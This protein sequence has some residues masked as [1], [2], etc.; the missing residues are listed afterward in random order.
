MSQRYLWGLKECQLPTGIFE[1]H[2]YDAWSDMNRLDAVSLACAGGP[3]LS[4]IFKLEVLIRWA[5]HAQKKPLLFGLAWAR[6]DDEYLYEYDEK[7]RIDGFKAI[8]SAA[9]GYIKTACMMDDDFDR[10]ALLMTV[11]VDSVNRAPTSYALGFE[12]GRWFLDR[13]RQQEED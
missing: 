6:I 1:Q 9:M 2:V 8:E 12:I 11:E 10:R 13:E 7:A 4:N 5:S 3:E